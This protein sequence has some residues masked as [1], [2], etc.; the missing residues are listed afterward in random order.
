MIAYGV[1]VLGENNQTLRGTVKIY[2]MS[3][4]RVTKQ[5]SGHNSGIS[6]LKFSPDGLLLASAGLDKKL[7]MWVVEHPED[8]PIQMTNNNGN[9]WD[10]SFTKDNNY[11]VASCNSGEI[12]VWPTDP[13]ALAELV[14]P[15]LTRNMT[16]EEWA[17]YVEKDQSP[18]I[19]CKSLVIE[20]F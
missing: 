5:L 1:E 9:I 11:L 16:P 17:L 14:C 3:Q 20:K 13:R 18:E 12:R 8:L 15:K 2:E 19:T 7:Q 10:I 4:Q 6:E